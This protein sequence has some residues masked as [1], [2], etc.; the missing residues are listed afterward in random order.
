MSFIVYFV[1]Q[2]FL[3]VVILTISARLRTIEQRIQQIAGE[4]LLGWERG[5]ALGGRLDRL[6]RSIRQRVP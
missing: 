6:I 1:T 3:F 4:A 5:P 2:G